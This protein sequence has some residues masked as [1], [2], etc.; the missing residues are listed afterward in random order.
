MN[1]LLHA[2]LLNWAYDHWPAITAITNTQSK[3]NFY[4]TGQFPELLLVR[5]DH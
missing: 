1:F 5:Q 2:R 4:L 3:V